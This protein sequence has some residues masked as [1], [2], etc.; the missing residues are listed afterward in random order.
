MRF[1]KYPSGKVFEISVDNPQV[2]PVEEIKRY[3]ELGNSLWLNKHEL[4][5]FIRIRH[6][7][8]RVVGCPD[9]RIDVK[10]DTLVITLP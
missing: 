5:E 2:F 9:V 10:G 4:S 7:L 3:V 1:S 8:A 6:S